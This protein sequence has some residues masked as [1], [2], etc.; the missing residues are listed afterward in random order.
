VALKIDVMLANSVVDAAQQ[1]SELERTGVD[2][3]F[4]FENAHDTF[5]PSSRPRR[6]AHWI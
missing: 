1:A 5:S 6:S 3:V 2:G 4:S